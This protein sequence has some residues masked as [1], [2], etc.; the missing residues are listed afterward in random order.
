MIIKSAKITE[1]TSLV[2]NNDGKFTL[3]H[4]MDITPILEANYHA[5]KDAQNGWS[6]DRNMRRVAS[7]DPLTWKKWTQKFP[8][9]L[10]GDRKLRDK[11]LYNLLYTEEGKQFW[12]VERGV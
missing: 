7:I 3:N 2:D 10:L 9:L 12:T 11:T 1:G 8:E 5:K 6:K 4:A